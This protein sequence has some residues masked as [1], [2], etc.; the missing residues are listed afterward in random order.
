MA[1]TNTNLSGVTNT[2]NAAS[3]AASNANTALNGFSF[4]TQG[5]KDGYTHN[6]VFTPFATGGGGGE[7]W[8]NEIQGT[9]NA[10][11]NYV[12][13]NIPSNIDINKIKGVMTIDFEVGINGAYPMSYKN[14]KKLFFKKLYNNDLQRVA[15]NI[16]YKDNNKVTFGC[17]SFAGYIGSGK[18]TIFIDDYGYNKL[19]YYDGNNNTL[20]KA[21][22]PTISKYCLFKIRILYEE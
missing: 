6:D 13:F 4:G 1:Q 21:E 11:S 10:S 17:I 22:G 12:E 8:S 15:C 9:L 2:A 16:H 7:V 3:T 14:T 20:Q 18:I 19:C 5:G